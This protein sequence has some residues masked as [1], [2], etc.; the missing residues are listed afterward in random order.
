MLETQSE[1]IYYFRLCFLF[2]HQVGY[3]QTDQKWSNLMCDKFAQAVRYP[4]G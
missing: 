3:T 1:I 2:F 4:A